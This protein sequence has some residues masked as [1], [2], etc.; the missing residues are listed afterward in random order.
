MIRLMSSGHQTHLIILP[1]L[2]NCRKT[3]R[4]SREFTPAKSGSPPL[5]TRYEMRFRQNRYARH[6]SN[7]FSHQR[8][9]SP[10]PNRVSLRQQFAQSVVKNRPVG[11]QHVRNVDLQR[12]C[13]RSRNFP[14]RFP[15]E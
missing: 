7:S 8:T 11:G 6:N 12:F 1:K 10:L 13:R 4:N 15:D 14:S 5:G 9:P 2:R 3:L